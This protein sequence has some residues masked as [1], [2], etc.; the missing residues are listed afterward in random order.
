MDFPPFSYVTTSIDVT[1]AVPRHHTDHDD[2]TMTLAI[3]P[4]G[5][6]GATYLA[7]TMEDLHRFAS[8]IHA[9]LIA[10]ETGTHPIGAAA[11]EAVQSANA[12][13]FADW[14]EARQES[15]EG[16]T[17]ADLQE[18]VAEFSAALDEMYS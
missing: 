8:A 14:L 7:G 13:G 1:L 2:G 18:L 5:Y 4:A 12:K 3:H 11:R 9:A 15:I 6:Y 17:D 16:A 10:H